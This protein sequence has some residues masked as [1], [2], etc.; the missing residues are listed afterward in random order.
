MAQ[1][2]IPDVRCLVL[3]AG[4]MARAHLCVLN[5]LAAGGCASFAPSDRNRAEVDKLGV[6][7]YSGSLGAALAD[8][9]PTHAVIATPVETLAP[10]TRDVLAAGVRNIL[11]EKPAALDLA[12]GDRVAREAEARGAQLWVAYNRR[13]YSSVRKARRLIRES[14]EPIMNVAFEFTEWSHVIEKLENQ[15]ALCKQRW[16]LANSMHVIDAA[17]HPVGLPAGPQSQFIHRNGLR[18]HESAS[19]FTGCGLTEQDVPFSY[20]A[21]WDAPG[22]WWFEWLTH[23]SRYIFRPLEKL[24]V[25][26]RGSVAIEE[27]PLD[28]DLDQRYK[29]GV[30]LQ[31]EQFLLGDPERNLVSYQYAMQLVSLAQIMGGY[32]RE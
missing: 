18:W 15:S 5:E 27:I 10:L 31:D 13:F 19:L 14:G 6:R 16:L 4:E 12:S 7:F 26:R 32:P 1:S 3:G 24:H 30:Y 2:R 17:L 23:S 29:P 11:V 20:F 21:N 22:R 28:D 8:Y 9:R 25:T